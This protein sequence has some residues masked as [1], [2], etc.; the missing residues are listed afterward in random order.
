[1]GRKGICKKWE[2]IFQIAEIMHV[3]INV[4]NVLI[5]IQAYQMKIKPV[6]TKPEFEANTKKIKWKLVVNPSHASEE[7]H[8]L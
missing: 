2:N 4:T 6:Q 1:M 8:R 7:T 3:L 5:K